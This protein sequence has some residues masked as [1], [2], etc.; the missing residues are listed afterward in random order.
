MKFSEVCNEQRTRQSKSA[1]VDVPRLAHQG[2]SSCSDSRRA[3]GATSGLPHNDSPA[4]EAGQHTVVSS[5]FLRQIRLCCNRQV[6]NAT[7]RAIH[8]QGLSRDIKRGVT[9]KVSRLLSFIGLKPSTP[10]G[11]TARLWHG[12]RASSPYSKLIEQMRIR[13][14][15][16]CF[17]EG[18]LCGKIKQYNGRKESV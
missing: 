7:R 15:F 12:W 16:A 8:V 3:C 17:P 9:S 10:H 18:K 1:S 11:L 5:G 6:A 4:G 13:C 14:S 2:H